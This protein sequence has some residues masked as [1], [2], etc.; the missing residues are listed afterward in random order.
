MLDLRFF[1]DEFTEQEIDF[2]I[3]PRQ[4][5][6]AIDKNSSKFSDF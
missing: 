6:K 4:N 3:I 5:Q 2:S 1:D